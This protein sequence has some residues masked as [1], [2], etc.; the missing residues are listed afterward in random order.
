MVSVCRLRQV[1][2]E[3]PLNTIMRLLHHLAPQIDE[4]VAR[5]EFAL[6]EQSI[7][8][9]IKNTTMV[10]GLGVSS[11]VGRVFERSETEWR[12]SECVGVSQSCRVWG[13]FSGFF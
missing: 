7:L 13:L 10:S 12:K 6:D 3:L 4:L 8:D 11:R 2:S 1:K 9:F 5:S